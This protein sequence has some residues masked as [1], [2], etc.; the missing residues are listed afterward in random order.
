MP[1]SLLFHS[2]HFAIIPTITIL[3]PLAFLAWL[4]PVVFGALAVFLRRWRILLAVAGIWS[5]VF[6]L[7]DWPPARLYGWAILC[8]T[9][10]TGF[11]WSWWRHRA[12]DKFNQAQPPRGDIALLILMSL[13]GLAVTLVCL[14]RGVL[15]KPPWNVLLLGWSV[16][17]V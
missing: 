9:A 13:V 6:A 11:C 8:L 2:H 10:I 15:F 5:A 14:G 17:W 12:A 7:Q 3:G 16:V 4:F 1:S